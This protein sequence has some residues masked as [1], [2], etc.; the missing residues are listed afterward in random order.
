MKKLHAKPNRS[1]DQRLHILKHDYD[2]DEAVEI[3][4]KIVV[5]FALKRI[6]NKRANCL[7]ERLEKIVK[8]NED[9]EKR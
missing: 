1:I 5:D 2:P 7:L 8:E 9:G 4:Q 6:T 3:A